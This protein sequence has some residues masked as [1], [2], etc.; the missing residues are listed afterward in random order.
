PLLT[1]FDYKKP[2]YTTGATI[3][4][5]NLILKDSAYLQSEDARRRN[6]RRA[7]QP[8]VEPLYTQKEV[9]RLNSLY[10]RLRYDYPTEAAPGISVRGV[11]AAHFLGWASLEMT[12]NGGGRKKV[13][14]FSGDLGPRGA[15]LH[16][17]PVPFKHADL[18]FMECT[19]GDKEHPSLAETAAAA[20]TAVKETVERGGR[21]LVPVFAVGRSQILLYLLAGA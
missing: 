11:E 14:V 21:V 20:R 9:D 18:V 8:P 13:V 2:I 12:V 3:A 19:Y 17:D 16:R 1:R 15:P 4:L 6:R 5:A 10:R 7:G